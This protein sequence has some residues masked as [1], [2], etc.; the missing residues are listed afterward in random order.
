[1]EAVVKEE[2]CRY[3]PYTPQEIDI[4]KTVHPK[5]SARATQH[6]RTI[7]SRTSSSRT[8][9]S[10]TNESRTKESRPSASRPIESRSI[11]SRPVRGRSRS[12]GNG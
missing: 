6:E 1:M 12:V 11:E 3:E 7:E 4:R 5:R 9:E 8:N 2:R 10:R